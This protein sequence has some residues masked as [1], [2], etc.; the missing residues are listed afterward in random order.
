M[1][2]ALRGSLNLR[3]LAGGLAALAPPAAA[4]RRAWI[5]DGQRKLAA[6]GWRGKASK[7]RGGA[8][9]LGVLAVEA[10]PNGVAG[11]GSASSDN[12]PS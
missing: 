11:I 1:I 8:R 4:A 7:G 9:F 12:R 6:L 5:A 3:E 10:E 2:S